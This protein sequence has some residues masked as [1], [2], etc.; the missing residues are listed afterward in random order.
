MVPFHYWFCN[1]DS[2]RIQKGL[3]SLVV[4]LFSQLSLILICA[5]LPA[6]THAFNVNLSTRK[7]HRLCL[8][9]E[10]SSSSS[11]E[12]VANIEKSPYEAGSHEELVYALGV[13]LARQLGDVRPLVENSAELTCVAK[14]LLDTVIGRLADEGQ[15]KLL[16]RRG[17]ELNELITQRA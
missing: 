8:A 15:R 3:Q 17:G 2:V 7:E 16:Q 12:M 1:R 14:G 6:V 10:S 13:N 9:E 5:A 11:T 4:M